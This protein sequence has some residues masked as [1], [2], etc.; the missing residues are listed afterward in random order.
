MVVSAMTW[1]KSRKQL[2]RGLV[3]RGDRHPGGE[4]G[5]KAVPT[6]GL[7][8]NKGARDQ[9]DPVQRLVFAPDLEALV[10]AGHHPRPGRADREASGGAEHEQLAQEAQ[11]PGGSAE[12][13]VGHGEQYQQDGQDHDVVGAGLHAQ[14]PPHRAGDAPVA[15][16][17][18]Q[19]HWVGGGQDRPQQ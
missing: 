7:A 12:V 9:T 10:D 3:E 19:H 8:G 15:Q 13:G 5:Q 1:P 2:H 18:A 17:V 11:P 14:R 4:G 16:D 6:D